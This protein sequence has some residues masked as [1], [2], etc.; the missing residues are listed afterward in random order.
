MGPLLC[1]S[2]CLTPPS[3]RH[4]PLALNP[5]TRHPAPETWRLLVPQR[6]HGINLRRPAGGPQDG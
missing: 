3:V 4:V 6:H 2:A 5:E 1:V